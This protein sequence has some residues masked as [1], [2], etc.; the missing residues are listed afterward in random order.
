MSH[1]KALCIT[2]TPYISELESLMAPYQENNMC[3]CPKEYLEF[4]DRTEE[5]LEEYKE[6]KAEYFINNHGK[7]VLLSDLPF[8]SID[9]IKASDSIEVITD[10]IA[11]I[12]S[13]DEFCKNDGCAIE[14]ICGEKRYGYYYN[15][16]SRWD[17]WS[18]MSP[19]TMGV[20]LKKD[21]KYPE[22][23]P[24]AFPSIIST[25]AIDNND[26]PRQTRKYTRV[27]EQIIEDAELEYGEPVVT[28]KEYPR[29]NWYHNKNDYILHETL[30]ALYNVYAVVTDSGWIE[31]MSDGEIRE[32]LEENPDKYLWIVDCHI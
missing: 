2:D 24:L 7:K 18:V 17:Y 29:V 26:L 16:N 14:E 11:N 9:K 19:D 13:F 22:E 28:A 15:P 31:E 23:H 27:W 30:G 3:D 5:L 4:D 12:I 8:S 10:T 21:E 20:Y 1:Y 32:M 25:I 6:R